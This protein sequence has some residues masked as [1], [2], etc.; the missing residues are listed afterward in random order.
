MSGIRRRHNDEEDEISTKRRKGAPLV[1]EVERKL[2]DIIGRV[3]DDKS[4][5][6]IESNLEG[7]CK[8]LQDD[9]DKYR[10][11]IIDII[12]GCAIY[13][14]QRA[15][16][17]ST[18]VGLLNAKNFNFGGD[19]VERLIAEQQELLDNEKFGEAQNLA[20]FLC[21]LGNSRVLTIQ[22]VGEYLESL[23]AAAFEDCVPQSRT[24]WFI[25]TVLR[26]L[27]WIGGE[28][29]E[30]ANEQL[31]NI[32]EGIGKYLEQRNKQ[33][34]PIL[35]VW[36]KQGSSNE[37][38]DYLDSLFAQIETLKKLD[39][40]EK[41]I[42]R[43]YVGFDV[44]LQDALQHNLPNFA[45]PIH[46]ENS[47][48]PYPQVVFRLFDYAD[49]S[50]DGMVL[51]GNHSIER[52]LIEVEI[53]WIIEKNQTN[54]KNCAK[55]LVAF[56]E[57]N[58]TVPMGYLIFET[59]FGQMF[60][61]PHS[62]LPQL[63]YGSLLLELC[64]IQATSYPQ[65]LVHSVELLY[66][67]AD[68]M[69]PECVDRLVD[70]FSFHL[71]NFQY[72][73]SWNDW[74]DCL[75]KDSF[76]GSVAFAREVIE[77]CRRL[78]SYDKI[79]AAIPSEFV[80]IQPTTPEVRYMLDDET[81]QGYAKA[82]TFQQMFQERQPAEAFISELRASD[83]EEGYNIDDF[84]VFVT[85]MLKMAA[86]TY[87]HN[88]SALSKYQNTLKTVCDFAERFQERL[89]DTL[90]SCWKTNQQMMMILIDKLLKMQ[91]LDCS[92]VI[93]WLF[94]DKL[95]QEHDRQW[96]FE[97]LNQAMEKLSRHIVSVEKDYKELKERIEKQDRNGRDENNGG[98][99]EMTVDDESKQ[100]DLEELE[101]QKNKF[102]SLLEFQKSLYME[103]LHKFI[104]ELT[105]LI[106]DCESEAIDFSQNPRY[107][108]LRGRFCQVFLMHSETLYKFTTA[109]NEEL[110]TNDVDANVLECYQQFL[111]LRH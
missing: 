35:Q 70:W 64:R 74:K 29:M 44:V 63:F 85:V 46:S 25:F 15:T 6:S 3:G 38:E 53:A 5:T 93:S 81:E 58:S 108:W 14:P 104:Q 41:H 82:Q 75:E 52:F 96:T 90:Y 77:K 106:G 100:K 24:D 76:C 31:E 33:H 102:D 36:S 92:Q 71:S 42:P 40:K 28:L 101:A 39:W 88:F 9:L 50:E 4:K 11:N 73:Y 17:Y 66:Q 89:L 16:V 60:R 47:K 84:E 57:E 83:P 23:V 37:Q 26:C 99:V 97:V 105:N 67:A 78:G 95:K 49:C 22:S 45:P 8:V 54:R 59:I 13:L 34:V 56:A 7:L 43:H 110:F 61:L 86:K 80:R 91:V 103:V 1:T 20:I 107:R 94:D 10:T 109:L 72:R 69:Q 12:T 79:I 18:L 65:I 32:L 51:P 19:V 98:D 2:Q 68:F 111:A 48:Y 87:S 21:D 27:P 55:E 30:K 62:P